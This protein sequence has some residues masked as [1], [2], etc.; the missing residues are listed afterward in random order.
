MSIFIFSKLLIVFP[1]D[2][3]FPCKIAKIHNLHIVFCKL[4][5]VL[6]WN[7]NSLPQLRCA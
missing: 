1:Y 5:C 7:K 2:I 6:P 3:V 4:S